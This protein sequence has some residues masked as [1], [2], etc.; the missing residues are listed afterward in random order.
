[1]NG[2]RTFGLSLA[3]CVVMGLMAGFYQ[4]SNPSAFAGP[5]IDSLSKDLTEQQNRSP[6]PL[7][8]FK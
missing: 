3:G 1:M 7:S 4:R 6:I 2:K 5:A 8:V